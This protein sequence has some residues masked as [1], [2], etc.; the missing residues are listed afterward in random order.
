MKSKVLAGT[1]VFAFLGHSLA[2]GA[3]TVP[4]VARE[5]GESVVFAGTEPAKLAFPLLQK[6][7][8]EV[9][10][11]YLPGLPH[12]IR[13]RRGRDYNVGSNGELQR[14]SNSRIPDYRRSA[15]FG[16]E[17]FDHQKYP[18]YGNKKF[19]AYVDYSYSGQWIPRP[20]PTGLG[21]EALA[22]VR[23][24][25]AAGKK[26]SFVAFGDS[27]T[28][29]G[30][31]TA[32]SLV[33]WERWLQQLRG[34]YPRA[35]IQGV[36]SGQ[37]GD[38]SDD[39]LARLDAA[40]I[41]HQPDLVLIAFGLNDF[42][43]GPVEIKM[44]KWEARRAKW[45]RSWAS[46]RGLPP[47]VQNNR[48]ER[49]AYFAMN[50]RAMVDRVKKETGADVILVSAL[51]PNPKWKYSNGDMAALAAAT[52]SVAREKGCAYVDVFDTWRDFSGR[53]QPEDL[54]ANNANHPN[55]FGHWIYFQA[56]AALR[57]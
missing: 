30:E 6:M 17:S 9:R 36:N 22:G 56:L 7:P 44:G 10:S 8:I 24:K 54:L 3:G 11:T 32:P 26:I 41:S 23:K 39:G 34:K 38:L 53:K 19:L 13:Y 35:S 29:G 15:V 5:A 37:G 33:Y 40:V 2:A 55:D 47:P 48:I 20:P 49:P 18:D 52:E 50:L 57:L 14:T 1:V 46:L 25:L 16:L 42:N 4:G 27:V 43:R 12:T 31:S 51:Q 28:A 45:A 21:A